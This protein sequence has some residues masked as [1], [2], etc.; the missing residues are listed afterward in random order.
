[1][2]SLMCFKGSSHLLGVVIFKAWCMTVL[3]IVWCTG[4]CVVSQQMS[5]RMKTLPSQRQ[6]ESQIKITWLYTFHWSRSIIRS[7]S[8]LLQIKNAWCQ[9]SEGWISPLNLWSWIQWRGE[10][11][12]GGMKC[13]SYIKGC[14]TPRFV[15]NSRDRQP[16]LPLVT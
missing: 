1:M 13:K 16:F 11:E 14:L 9:S 5:R 15:D 12:Y 8:F 3:V 7:Q 4:T 2:F 6:S 10:N